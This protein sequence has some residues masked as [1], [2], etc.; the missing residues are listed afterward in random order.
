MVFVFDVDDSPF[1]GAGSDHFAVDVEGF[2]GTDY[3]EGDFVLS[4]VKILREGTTLIAALR[5]RSSS[6]NSSLS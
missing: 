3:G 1:V 4:L 5:A 6:S 2:L